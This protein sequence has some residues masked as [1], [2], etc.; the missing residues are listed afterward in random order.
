MGSRWEKSQQDA[1][2][3]RAEREA[4]L[5]QKQVDQEEKDR[6]DAQAILDRKEK[7]RIDHEARKQLASEVTRQRQFE[8]PDAG[9]T[10]EDFI[11]ESD[12]PLIE[13]VQGLHYQGNNTLL[14]AEHKTGK[15][16]LEINLA[17]ALVDGKPF[18]GRFGTALPEG[19][20]AFFNYEMGKDQF[21]NW[22]NDAE[23]DN[24]DRIVPLNLRGFKLPFWDEAELLRL[25]EWLNKNE[26]SFIIM[27]PA[28]KSWRGLV[29]NESDN[30]QLAE[31]FGA[32]DTLKAEAGVP[33]LLLAVH[34]PRDA[35]RARGGGEIEAWP[36]ANWY[37]SKMKGTKDRLL[38]AEGRDV[39]MPNTVLEYNK[40]TR[41]LEAAEGD[42]QD[43]RN[44]VA[45]DAAVAACE[46]AGGF[47]S[48]SDFVNAL[49]GQPGNSRRAI[50]EAVEQGRVQEIAEGN[51]KKYTPVASP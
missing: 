16:T 25:A 49:T 35:E 4:E 23:I 27:D 43:A 15:T 31:F 26:V 37:L 40:E 3:Q 10:A 38:R 14:V 48:L 21:R 47:D 19:K 41:L 30:V 13:V 44:R 46:G 11:E 7:L 2:R 6:R 36:D 28:S 9:W 8:L 32:V 22:L 20:V 33:N 17:A 34:T 42:P 51:N 12:E 29:E 50:A 5:R 24:I 45:V 18:L 39:E 1:A